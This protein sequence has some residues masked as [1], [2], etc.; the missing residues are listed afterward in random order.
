MTNN[1]ISVTLPSDDQWLHFAHDL[2]KKYGRR[3]GFSTQL[4]IIFSNSVM[5]AYEELCRLSR[6]AGVTDSIKLN[7][8]F[9][10]GAV[11][12]DIIYNGRI[13]LNPHKTEDFEVPDQETEFDDLDT[14]A[15]WLHL[16]KH[17]MDR[18]RFM[19]RGSRHV[20]RLI[21]YSREEGK[22]KQAW[23]M[24]IKPRLRRRLILHLDDP[25]AEHPSGV[26]QARGQGVLKLSPSETFI[27]QNMDG[28]TTFYDLYMAHVD[29]IGL[30]SP[31]QLAGLYEQ[32]ER[33]DML[34]HQGGD[35][36]ESKTKRFIKRMVNP[37]FSI[38]NADGVVT[39]AHGIARPL[40]TSGG[41]IL[42]LGLG[43]SGL[44]PWWGNLGYFRDM[45]AGLEA[46]FASHPAFMI[47]LY[48]LILVNIALHELG[49]GVVCK[50]YGGKVP[51]LGIM[52]YLAMFIFY[53]DTTAAWTFPKK[54]Q[55]ILVSLGGPLLSF[56]V[57]GAGLW[58]TA[59]F[60]HTDSIWEYVFVGFSLFNFFGLVMN[61]NPFIKMDA[62]YMLVDYTGIADLRKKSF[63]F[64]QR[65]IFDKLGFGSET[66][67]YTPKP[68][69]REQRTFWWYGILGSLVSVFFLLLP[70]VRI[71]YLLQAE[72]LSQG[73]F[74]LALLIGAILLAR[75][76]QAAFSKIKAMRY[77]EYKIL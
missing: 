64:L 73:R 62:Y 28:E 76:G 45:I 29:A 72:S 4:E 63:T 5:E 11:I 35:A 77:R 59:Y 47:P 75:L 14:S 19:V 3:V 42:L 50:H 55:R 24:A 17:R 7:F 44:I 9:N 20:L 16:I 8:E 71:K 22:E 38:P 13:P 61:F 58:A 34:A 27:I 70:I 52:F 31:G 74:L 40:F 18:V 69:Q 26:L 56:A 15:L 66:T 21:K 6:E 37:D 23:V 39:A 43:F 32:L 36:E 57:F 67:G 65:K 49:H 1:H 60:A 12:V 30:I 48:G 53:C 68:S 41:L 54:R 2:V 33:M 25:D 51:R 46:T 10:G